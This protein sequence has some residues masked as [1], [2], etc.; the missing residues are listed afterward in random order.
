[1][2]EQNK[3]VW[4]DEKGLTSACDY[5]PVAGF[6]SGLYDD[7]VPSPSGTDKFR[8][9]SRVLGRQAGK[10]RWSRASYHGARG[11]LS[12]AGN[13]LR[14]LFHQVTGLFFVIFG[15]IVG[16]AAYREY[17]AYQSGKIGSG[18]ALLAGVLAVLFLYFGISAVVRAG[19]KK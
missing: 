1:M 8:A 4:F 15:V 18:R 14:S 7:W 19:R 2:Q 9:V 11:F 13:V 3:R 17:V 5:C 16:F 6:L 10:S 12:A